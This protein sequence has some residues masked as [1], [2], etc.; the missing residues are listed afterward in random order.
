[1]TGEVFICIHATEN[2]IEFVN[3]AEDSNGKVSCQ[4]DVKCTKDSNG[5]WSCQGGEDVVRESTLP[6][7]LNDALDAAIQESQDTTKVPETGVLD[8]PDALSDDESTE[9]GD[10]T[11][12]PHEDILPDDGE[13]TINDPQTTT[14]PK[15]KVPGKIEMPNL[16]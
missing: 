13:P 5:K 12:V 9:N 3:C 6:P 1:M 8:E 2:S 15:I 11:K 7:A 10:D 14:E 16:K 4:G